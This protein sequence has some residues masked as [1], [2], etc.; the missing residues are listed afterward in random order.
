M[1]DSANLALLFDVLAD[2]LSALELRAV[3][4]GV[5]TPTSP[6]PR[7]AN[8][9]LELVEHASAL[10]A[11][12]HLTWNARLLATEEHLMPPT[13]ERNA[14]RELGRDSHAWYEGSKALFHR[15]GMRR[16]DPAIVRLFTE[17]TFEAATNPHARRF[18]EEHGVPYRAIFKVPSK[19]RARMK[20]AALRHA[21]GAA[22]NP[23]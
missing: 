6:I 20:D 14:A 13:P 9:S 15:I 23:F 19:M 17:A 8:D 18:L 7:P 2:K 5:E 4:L 3:A 11:E 10:M 21:D 12:R 16:S 22:P 1:S